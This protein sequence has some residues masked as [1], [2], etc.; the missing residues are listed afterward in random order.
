MTNCKHTLQ[1]PLHQY[2]AFACLS[3]LWVLQML[4]NQPEYK[5]LTFTEKLNLLEEGICPNR[6]VKLAGCNEMMLNF[7]VDWPL[8]EDAMKVAFE[9]LH[10]RHSIVLDGTDP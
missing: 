10:H 9:N 1:K 6:T 4:I 5:M 2:T 3:V 7:A 8:L